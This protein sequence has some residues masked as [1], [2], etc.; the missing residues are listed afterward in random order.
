[1]QHT[2]GL[3][4][5]DANAQSL[6]AQLANGSTGDLMNQLSYSTIGRRGRLQPLCRRHCGYGKD[7]CLAAYGAFPIHSRAGAA[8]QGYAQPAPECSAFVPR[9]Q[10]GGGGGAAAGWTSQSRRRCIRSIPQRGFALEKPGL[11]LPAEGAPLV[12]STQLAYELNLHIETRMKGKSTAVDLPVKA[13]PS[14]G[15]SGACRI[16]RLRL[17]EGDLT[18]V[19]RGKWGFDD[20]EGPRFHLHAAQPGK[21]TLAAGD[22]SALVVGREDTL[23]LE[24]DS[25]LCVDRVEEQPEGGRPVKLAWKS[26]KPDSLEV[27]VPMKDAAPG[28]VTLE[29]YQFGLEKP[30][31]LPL[32]AYAEAASLDRLTLS[33]GDSIAV[34]NGKRLDEVAKAELDGITLTPVCAEPGGGFRPVGS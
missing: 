19:L 32:K 3:V 34:L 7:S 25:T 18:A 14:A 15:R 11:V 1:M 30:D 23:H 4:L 5:D 26:P 20:W 27:A 22:Q 28:P 24:D 33:A 31:R 13:D 17:P 10:I 16:R 8:D 2:D 21:W 9:S 29:I 12:F 6:V